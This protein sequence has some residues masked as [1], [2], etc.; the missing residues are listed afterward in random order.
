MKLLYK[1]FFLNPF[2]WLPWYLRRALSDLV[3]DEFTAEVDLPGTKCCTFAPS[4][5][6]SI[7]SVKTE[8]SVSI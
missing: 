7:V 6:S 1:T 5:V 4:L 3:A 8:I 2:I